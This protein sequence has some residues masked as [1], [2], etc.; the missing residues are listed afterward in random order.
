MTDYYYGG[1]DSGVY[2]SEIRREPSPE[3]VAAEHERQ[4]ELARRIAPQADLADF[5]IREL[6]GGAVL[7]THRAT[8][9]EFRRVEEL[10]SEADAMDSVRA[11]QLGIDAF[12]VDAAQQIH[13]LRARGKDAALEADTHIGTVV[14]RDATALQLRESWI[15]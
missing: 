1:P 10:V 11:A 13:Y 12:V 4:L 2:G 3:L 15:Q 7:F 6:N 5:E 9:C 14:G 8:R